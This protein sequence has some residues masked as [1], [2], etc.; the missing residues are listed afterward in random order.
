M[1]GY[2]MLSFFNSIIPTLLC[3]C[4]QHHACT[5]YTQLIFLFQTYADVYCTECS[6]LLCQFCHLHF[7]HNH[8]YKVL[9]K[10]RREINSNM[11]QEK[12]KL[13]YDKYYMIKNKKIY[14]KSYIY[15]HLIIIFFF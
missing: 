4:I 5:Y 9:E 6:I 2:I 13:E 11:L 8:N 12:F 15:P 1:Y 3:Q 7:H 14:F 10:F